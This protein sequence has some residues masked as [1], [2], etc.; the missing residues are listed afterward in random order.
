LCLRFQA[1]K[2][3]LGIGLADAE[4]PIRMI[5]ETTRQTLTE[6]RPP[7]RMLE[8]VTGGLVLAIVSFA[9]V[10]YAAYHGWYAQDLSRDWAYAGVGYGFMFYS[11]GAFI[12]AYGWEGGDMMKALRLG[13]FICAVT[14][15]TIIALVMLLKMRADAAGKS[16]G[17]AAAASKADFDGASLLQ[18]AGSMLL[19]GQEEDAAPKVSRL[20][21]PFQIVCSACGR[22]FAPAPPSAKCPYCL[23]AALS[24]G[25]RE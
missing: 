24:S 23:T 1:A 15:L 19:P 9:V 2:P 7:G 20:D 14:L 18:T 13:F 17:A 10:V 16:A 8:F 21:G 12:F 3:R 11:L 5:D 4:Y 6:L 22:S 25:R